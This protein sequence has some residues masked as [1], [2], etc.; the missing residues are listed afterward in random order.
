MTGPRRFGR[1]R[2]KFHTGRRGQYRFRPAANPRQFPR[3]CDRRACAKIL[4]DLEKRQ[5][6]I[7]ELDRT[8]F[9]S[10]DVPPSVGLLEKVA[11]LLDASA[12]SRGSVETSPRF[13]TRRDAPGKNIGAKRRITKRRGKSSIACRSR[14]ATRNSTLF[15]G[16]SAT[17]R[18]WP[19]ISATLRSPIKRFSSSPA[20]CTS[21]CPKIPN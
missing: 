21:F 13:E 18:I 9:Q 5:A 14:F 4:E 15:A 7:A 17:W 10:G 1:S 11:R 20:V 16:R 12:Q 8:I 19:G 3:I 2:K 6:E